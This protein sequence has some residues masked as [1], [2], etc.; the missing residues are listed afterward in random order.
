MIAGTR[1]PFFRDEMIH[2]ARFAAFANWLHRL[3]AIVCGTLLLIVFA[4][5]M[6]VVVLRYA[7][8]TGFLELQDVVAYAF[9]TLVVLSIPLALRADRHVRVDVFRNYQPPARQRTIDRLA[10]VFLLLPVFALTLYFAMPGIFYSWSIREGSIETG[11]LP[12][13]FIVK[14]ALPVACIVMVVQGL[15]LLGGAGYRGYRETDHR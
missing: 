1:E 3:I 14:T 9:A 12:G 11:G 7:F 15:A 13:Y 6:S 5:Q 2:S 10:I 4:G 8:S